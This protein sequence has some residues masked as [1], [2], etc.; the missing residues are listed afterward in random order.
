MME[1]DY[2]NEV[3]LSERHSVVVL[4]APVDRRRGIGVDGGLHLCDS[5][6]MPSPFQSIPFRTT[7]RQ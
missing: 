4:W 6:E 3:D 7:G 1:K 2:F 5:D